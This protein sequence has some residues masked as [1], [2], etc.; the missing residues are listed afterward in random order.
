MNQLISLPT[1][2]IREKGNPKDMG[3]Y[4]VLVLNIRDKHF[5]VLHSART[6]KDKAFLATALKIIDGIKQIGGGTTIPQARRLTIGDY[7]KSNTLDRITGKPPTRPYVFSC[8][9]TIF[10]HK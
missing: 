2:E 1:L 3:H 5:E 6:L 8:F 9:F 10:C 7:K 4:W